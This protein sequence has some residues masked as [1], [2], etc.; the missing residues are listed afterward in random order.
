[1]TLPLTILTVT[2]SGDLEQF[3][4]LRHSINASKLANISHKVIVQT[5][6]FSCFERFR[7][8]GVELI[9]S[10]KVLPGPV[11]KRR[12][13]ARR[14]QSLFGVRLTKWWGSI[15]RLTGFPVWVRYTGWH[16]QQI[17]KLAYAAQC[18]SDNIFVLDSDVVVTPNA[19]L[20]QIAGAG[21]VY[22]YAQWKDSITVRG[23]VKNWQITAH[24]LFNL[25]L[26]KSN[27]WD[28]YYDTPFIL[29]S[30]TV[31]ELQGWLEKAYKKD[32]WQVLFDLP[33]RRWSEFG[34]YKAFL[35]NMSSFEYVNKKPEEI[36]G[37]ISKT[38]D[39][40]DLLKTFKRMMNKEA[41]H[42]ITIHSQS[43]GKHS[44][45]TLVYSKHIKKILSTC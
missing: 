10:S 44:S 26:S 15:S 40:D 19:C 38:Q 23:K 39:K 4:L 33:P 43:S 3:A 8:P 28:C 22:C 25:D 41:L 9:P 7:A 6:D 17:C 36:I 24:K 5:E 12:L 37:Y 1:M 16:T 21:R 30:A 42:F 2:W 29:H 13:R 35:R 27:I 14:L 18:S 31:K 11:E 45:S 20:P 34:I 32:W